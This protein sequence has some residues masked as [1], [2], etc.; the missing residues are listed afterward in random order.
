MGA[1]NTSENTRLEPESLASVSTNLSWRMSSSA[2]RVWR[3]DFEITTQRQ[4]D[5]NAQPTL[6]HRTRSVELYRYLW[7]AIMVRV[8]T[9]KPR[10]HFTDV[11]SSGTNNALTN[12]ALPFFRHKRQQLK[13]IFNQN[14][15]ANRSIDTTE[16]MNDRRDLRKQMGVKKDNAGKLP[17]KEREE[18]S[19]SPWA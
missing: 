9:S 4:I 18:P 8:L 1:L 15:T 19:F 14:P 6:Y 3:S 12:A 11:H 7:I 13:S 2:T 17:W 16:W 10:K 5:N